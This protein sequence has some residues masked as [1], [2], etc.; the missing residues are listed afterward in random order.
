MFNSF[1]TTI[2]KTLEDAKKSKHVV[3]ERHFPIYEAIEEYVKKNSL[4]L[5]N[6]ETLLDESYSNIRSYVIYGNNILRHANNLSN[7]IAQVT[8]YVLMYTTKVREDFTIV[9]DG[10]PMVQLQNISNKLLKTVNYICVKGINMYP[11][12]L[13]LIEVYHKLYLPQFSKEWENLEKWE[14]SLMSMVEKRK[15]IFGGRRNKTKM[16]KKRSRFNDRLGKRGV[17]NKVILNWLK[18]RDDYVLLG[19]NAVNILNKSRE[20]SQ[21]IQIITS[22]PF[23]KIVSEF[24]NMIFQ[25]IGVEPTN[26]VHVVNIPSDP[27]LK[28]VVISVAVGHKK[29]NIHLMDV[30]NSSNYELVPYIVYDNLNIGYGYV[31]K[32]FLLVDIWFMQILFHLNYITKEYLK[33]SIETSFSL[34][35]Q[36]KKVKLSENVRVEYIGTHV[37]FVIYKKMLGLSNSFYP[38]NP[39]RQ[40]YQTGRYRN[41]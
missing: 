29:R 22:S 15:S 18:Q 28:K 8:I 11:P 7:K 5:S 9:V 31:L 34:M 36:V 38:Y 3:H 19:T 23:D 1:L 40:R 6:V 13:E 12:E 2:N 16:N 27:R 4:I 30:F 32:R 24:S 39:E 33:R 17:D 20:Y 41:I 14:T 25:Y 26:K 21:K 35:N 37:D 10:V